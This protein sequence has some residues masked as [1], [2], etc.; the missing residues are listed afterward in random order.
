MRRITTGDLFYKQDIGDIAFDKRFHL[1]L[2]HSFLEAKKCTFV[3]A[4]PS[5]TPK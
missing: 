2:A 4:M 5:P 1:E 3:F